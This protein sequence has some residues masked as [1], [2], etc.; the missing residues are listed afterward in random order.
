MTC[1][2][3]F[4]DSHNYLRFLGL[5][6]TN[7]CKADIFGTKRSPSEKCLPEY[8]RYCPPNL[9]VSG[10]GD[11]RQIIES[12]KR[13]TNRSSYVQKTFYNLFQLTQG[14]V[15]PRVDIIEVSDLS[16]RIF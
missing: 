15:Q 14:Y 11:E 10:N 16:Q 3:D 5:S 8:E 1:V 12:L 2:K 7:L 6:L 9:V 13:Y 4:I